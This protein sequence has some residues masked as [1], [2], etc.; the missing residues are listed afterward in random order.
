MLHLI[1]GVL[2]AKREMFNRKTRE[3]ARGLYTDGSCLDKQRAEFATPAD[4]P[5]E[6][7]KV[8]ARA[9]GTKSHRLDIM[10]LSGGKRIIKH[11]TAIEN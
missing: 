7:R 10:K 4:T 6:S 1:Y 3:E 9:D 5:S 8:P 11:S 2:D